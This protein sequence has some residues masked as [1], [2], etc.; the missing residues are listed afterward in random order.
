MPKVIRLYRL[1]KKEGGGDPGQ[2][3][4][5][6]DV[7]TAAVNA[8]LTPLNEKLSKLETQLQAN[9]ESELKTKRDAVKAKFPFMTEAAINSLAGDALN[10]MYSQCQTST[11][12]NPSFHQVNAENDQWKD[13]D[14]NAGMDQEKK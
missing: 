10:D 11:G 5:N 1:Q 4:I 6:S 9:A 12:L 2:A 14:L 8:A 3:Q 13:Y 7:I